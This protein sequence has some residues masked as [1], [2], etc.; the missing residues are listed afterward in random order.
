VRKRNATHDGGS[1]AA[2]CGRLCSVAAGC[3]PSLRSWP[4]IS[5]PLLPSLLLL[6]GWSEGLR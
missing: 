1:A 5:L 4:G 2:G 6:E 3:F